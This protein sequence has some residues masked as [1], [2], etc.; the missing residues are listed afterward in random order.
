METANEQQRRI[1]VEDM[2]GRPIQRIT[3]GDTLRGLSTCISV[4]VR[5]VSGRDIEAVMYFDDYDSPFGCTTHAIKLQV[6]S[7]ASITVR[8]RPFEHVGAEGFCHLMDENG[9]K[10]CMDSLKVWTVGEAEPLQIPVSCRV[11]NPI[12][13][14]SATSLSFGSCGLM[15]ARTQTFDIRND[16][17]LPVDWAID[18]T[19]NFMFEPESSILSPHHSQNI[20]VR[21]QPSRLGPFESETHVRYC[22]RI[23]SIR[24]LLEGHSSASIPHER[25]PRQ[26]LLSLPDNA[27]Q[28]NP[29]KV[30]LIH[31]EIYK[32]PFWDRESGLAAPAIPIADLSCSLPHVPRMLESP[33]LDLKVEPTT[34]TEH[35]DCQRVVSSEDL[36]KLL[37]DPP[38][39]RISLGVVYARVSYNFNVKIRNSLPYTIEASLVDTFRTGID[40]LGSGSLVL[41]PSKTALFRL[42]MTPTGRKKMFATIR[43]NGQLWRA[44]DV[45]YDLHVKRIEIDRTP[46]S[47]E[48]PPENLDMHTNQVLRLAN[49]CACEVEYKWGH[50][51]ASINISPQEGILQPYGID[52]CT[53]T[54]LPDPLSSLIETNVVCQVPNDSFHSPAESYS[55]SLRGACPVSM[56]QLVTKKLD[57]GIISVD[58]TV[59][60]KFRIANVG[61]YLGVFNATLTELR[62]VRIDPPRGVIEPGA[63]IELDLRASFPAEGLKEETV[64]ISIRGARPLNLNVAATCVV[65]DLSL[66]SSI[67]A[68]TCVVGSILKRKI[69]IRND[70]DVVAWVG[71]PSITPPGFAFVA[72]DASEL[73]IGRKSKGFMEMTFSPD[74]EGSGEAIV[75]LRIPGNRFL[76]LTVKWHISHPPVTIVP[77]RAVSFG[78]IFTE[79]RYS[80]AF[81]LQLADSCTSASWKIEEAETAEIRI[82]P[83][84]GS[85]IATCPTAEV[86]IE[87][88][89]TDPRKLSH[90]LNIIINEG[91]ACLSLIVDAD[92]HTPTATLSPSVL[93]FGMVAQG[94][95]NTFLEFSAV[96]EGFNN[97][98]E[99]FV[100]KESPA[101]PLDISFPEGT[102]L[103]LS[104]KSLPVRVHLSTKD[105]VSLHTKLKVGVRGYDNTCTT[106]PVHAGVDSS[107]LSLLPSDPLT[108]E[109]I[110][111]AGR[112]FLNALNPAP[113]TDTVSLVKH[114]RAEPKAKTKK[115]FA[116]DDAVKFLISRGAVFPG[117]I[118]HD[119]AVILQLC[120][121]LIGEREGERLLLDWLKLDSPR[122]PGYMKSAIMETILTSFPYL[123]GDL[124]NS[125]GDLGLSHLNRLV[126]H[127]DS[128]PVGLLMAATIREF[129]Q[130]CT[131]N[132]THVTLT[133]IPGKSS[134]VHLKLERSVSHTHL[135]DSSRTLSL[136][137]STQGIRVTY[138]SRFPRELIEGFLHLGNQRV[139]IHASS[140]ADSDAIET[141]Q[142][143][144]FQNT[145]THV[146]ITVK[147]PFDESGAFSI[148]PVDSKGVYLKSS[149]PALLPALSCGSFEIITL[150]ILQPSVERCMLR[151]GNLDIGEFTVALETHILPPVSPSE[152]VSFECDSGTERSASITIP[153]INENLID[154]LAHFPAN[155][156]STL[157]VPTTYKLDCGSTAFGLETK[158]I[159]FKDRDSAD[160]VVTFRP[161]V[162]GLYSTSLRISNE[163]DQR[164]YKLVGT[165][166]SP[167]S[168]HVMK[169]ETFARVPLEQA[170]PLP[171]DTQW[172]LKQEKSAPGILGIFLEDHR[173]TLTLHSRVAA[174]AEHTFTL[175]NEC[176]MEQFIMTV[177][178]HVKSPLAEAKLA[179][180]CTAREPTDYIISLPMQ[181][182]ESVWRVDTDLDEI[183]GEKEAITSPNSH[184]EYRLKVK[185][186]SS[187][188]VQ[189]SV[190][191]T[192]IDTGEMFWYHV[193]LQ[194]R[195]PKDAGELTLRTIV[196]SHVCMIIELA[197][198]S[199]TLATFTAEWE[200]HGLSGIT[201][202]VIEPHASYKY[203]LSYSP[204]RPETTEGSIAFYS[205]QIGDV[206]YR[207][208]LISEPEIIEVDLGRFEVVL[209][210]KIE[211]PM[212]IK[213][214]S[215]I[216]INLTC[217]IHST[218][219]QDMA[220]P[221]RS[222][223]IR[224]EPGGEVSPVLLYFPSDF[225]SD[226][227]H[228]IEWNDPAVGSWVFRIATFTAAPPI[229]GF[230]DI[231]VNG[232]VG[233]NVDGSI[234]FQNPFQHH[235]NLE[236]N[237]TGEPFRIV[238]RKKI[239]ALR[240]R[241][242]LHVPF[243]FNP[244]ESRISSGT[245]SVAI[246]D[247]KWIYNIHGRPERP[248]D[249]AEPWAITGRARELISAR[250]MYL[251]NGLSQDSTRPDCRNADVTV[252][253]VLDKM[254][255]P[256]LIPVISSID[257]QED[258]KVS[259]GV[260]IDTYI[261]RPLRVSG[262]LQLTARAGDRWRFPI[263]LDVSPPAVD[264]VINLESTLTKPESVSFDIQNSVNEVSD[265]K[266]FF[267]DPKTD[268][269]ITSSLFTI[270]PP[271]GTLRPE[272]HG[273]NRFVLTFRPTDYGRSSAT[274]KLVIETDSAYWSFLVSGSLPLY[275]PPSRSK[276]SSLPS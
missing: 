101:V 268:S 65:P 195:P 233:T 217:T 140:P 80:H 142:I 46:I 62:P 261:M 138:R 276:H 22:N 159:D 247:L 226:Y 201:S 130:E 149:K 218:R 189:G 42:R 113:I 176:T 263:K 116:R 235:V 4:L 275:K 91:A 139:R 51:P 117:T 9:F 111:E 38:D 214:S 173:L 245:I 269:T 184:S 166:R 112:L 18:R 224:V 93:E 79:A 54:Y 151:I 197:N 208:D 182:V 94:S 237:C 25:I 241:E 192:N 227:T 267:V 124:V 103:P 40:I 60:A 12:L 48:F 212:P 78:K 168:T 68:F 72:G 252:E 110:H 236:V 179:I 36:S 96:N 108:L 154:A 225:G 239:H 23:H 20:R 118:I 105:K 45:V 7:S 33:D 169:L 114:F 133:G 232:E 43:V 260:S 240:S 198:P 164:L 215:E 199:E 5:C 251:V 92:I 213:N 216:P 228:R 39:F 71:V 160:V 234:S 204:Q 70:S 63:S 17:Q 253:V 175:V 106:L 271:A 203:Q 89:P 125:L 75:P 122:K 104:Q 61:K 193:S 162:P 270:S 194:A 44:I 15:D 273:S 87:L 222:T 8:L 69:E 167:P 157:N 145:L 6:G 2:E 19:A 84:M 171:V 82:S 102:A 115:L 259:V 144:V 21:F 127:L 243:I 14:L 238:T 188:L 274:V 186:T 229:T 98:V 141:V 55:I 181:A 185:L 183:F 210:A 99:I 109:R 206:W 66:G 126:P 16:S 83:L 120:K 257:H 73:Q 1:Q 58:H 57:L 86:L 32:S 11:F 30:H 262:L 230:A 248:I 244:L 174:Q 35:R 134:S 266:A 202:F 187:K 196:R 97:P 223:Q 31:H 265:F 156:Q 150:A 147:N 209:G 172:T 136:T 200:G 74:M 37:V 10:T 52:E 211:I 100:E 146:V 131:A 177:H 132:E 27:L 264:D 249:R 143:Q 88:T 163:G 231:N 56:C 258:G 170:I 90:A 41:P 34:H 165:A 67:E 221:C 180:L 76:R 255:S 250:K 107:I 53:V 191:F 153:R 64:A 77:T 148:S 155:S 47:L 242:I 161:Q 81:T 119:G 49:P 158:T 219:R 85:L 50:V 3:L 137:P 178:A 121:L 272:D 95:S 135:F 190:T 26:G 220:L 254:I 128:D 123:S 28:F 13:R 29:N 59:H 246:G 205:D 207:L 129:M 256:E 152:T 24:I